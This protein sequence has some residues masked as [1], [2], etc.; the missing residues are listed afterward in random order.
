V[1]G[2]AAHSC[3]SDAARKRQGPPD[4][5]QRL[6]MPVVSSGSPPL[7]RHHREVRSGLPGGLPVREP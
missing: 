1:A 3:R 7:Q 6:S 2:S 4:Q 5:V